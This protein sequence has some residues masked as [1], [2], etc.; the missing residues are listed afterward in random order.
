M[1]KYAWHDRPALHLQVAQATEKDSQ[2]TGACATGQHAADERHAD[3]DVWRRQPFVVVINGANGAMLVLSMPLI[4][5]PCT[6]VRC[7]NSPRSANTLA[8][9]RLVWMRSVTPLMQTLVSALLETA[10]GEGVFGVLKRELEFNQNYRPRDEARADLF[11]YME[12]FHNPRMRRRVARR[13]QKVAALIKPSM[14]TG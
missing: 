12:R 10:A 8:C 9:A 4:C 6:K 13:D 1:V 7:S 5:A 14:E 2:V 11:D 3:F